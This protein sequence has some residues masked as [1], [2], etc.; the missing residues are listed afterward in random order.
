MALSLR[1]RHAVVALAVGAGVV[2]VPT[3]FAAPSGETS[4]SASATFEQPFGS[5]TSVAAAAGKRAYLV[6]FDP[7]APATT[8][9]AIKSAVATKGGTVY[10]AY[11]AIGTLVAHSTSATFAADLRGV[12]GVQKVGATRTSDVPAAADNPTIPS[13]PAQTIPTASE[14]S[15]YDMT[16]IGADKA[17]AVNQGSPDVVVGVLDTGVDDLHYDLKDN[18]VASKSASCAYGKL[19]TRPGAWREVHTHG[20]HVAG[21]IAAGKNGKGM[22]GVAPGVKIASVRVAEPTTSLFF[23]ENTICSF[24]FAG[25]QGFDVTNNSYYVD[26]WMFNCPSNLDQAAILEG[27]K[28][29]VAYAE[30]KGVLNVAAAGNANY[31]LA[32]KSTDTTSP[33]DSTATT[34]TVTNDCLDLP[35]ELPG[36]VATSSTTSSNAK[37]SF[38]NFGLNKIQLAAPG[39]GVYSTVPGGGYISNDGTSMASPH[40]AGVAA[41]LAS[42]HPNDTPAQLRAKLYAQADDLA[43]PSDSRCTGTTANNAFF[44]EG[45]VDAFEAVNT[46]TPGNTVTVTNPGNQT[47]TVGT[48]ASLQIQASDSDPNQ[49]LTYSATGL[50]AGLTINS[51]TGL[52]SGT[53]TTAATSSVT[54]TVKDTTNVSKSVTFSWT[55]GTTTPS[56][57]QNGVPV[58]GLSGAKGAALRFTMTVPAGVTNLKFVTTGGTGDPDLYAKLGTAPTTTSHD[59]KS[60]GSATAETCAITTAGAG[61]YHVLISGYSAFS[62]VSLT[63]SYQTDTTAT[64]TNGVGQ[65]PL[66]G[67]QGSSAYFK[68]E[69]PAGATNLKFTTTSGTGDA[70]LYVRSASKPTT[71]AYTCKSESATT[72]ETCTI[73]S[74]TPGTYY[75]L[76]YGYSAFSGTTLTGSYTP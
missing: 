54:V 2:A 35:A 53:P 46:G 15:R 70:D 13:A 40:V 8:V 22:V 12:T 25:D 64:L 37:S 32:A 60:E 71:S 33:N 73:S 4:V 69:V 45:R 61:T 41:L 56:G 66:S 10:A 20:T 18:F 72:A 17:W 47:S 1:A 29:A 68:L 6:L 5:A 75:V 74:I 48:A 11:D 59:C 16:I 65:G 3:A 50:P 30:G 51:S 76:V 44:G 7:A 49:T 62:G 21:T 39:S 43:C 38:S 28:R 42:V 63:G 55:V 19:D 26:P 24:I 34:R 14:T 27:V 36:V 23:P 9:S 31:N 57:L 58:T 67:A 52:I